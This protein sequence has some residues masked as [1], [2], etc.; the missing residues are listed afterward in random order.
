F[1]AQ[2]FGTPPHEESWLR[3]VLERLFLPWIKLAV[4][5]LVDYH[6][7]ISAVTNNWLF[8]SIRKDY[9][10][11]ARKVI[12]ALWGH[13]STMFTKGIVVVDADVNVHD[14]DSVWFAVGAQIDPSRDLVIAAGPTDIDDHASPIAGVGHKL[15]IDATRKLPEERPSRPWPKALS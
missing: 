10:F 7:P 6:S 11:A 12:H 4:P 15:G 13:P 1:P 8:V 2:V 9:P 3:L 14:S 5:E